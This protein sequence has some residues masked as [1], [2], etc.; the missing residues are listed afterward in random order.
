MFRINLSCV[1]S[2][3]RV[4]NYNFLSVLSLIIARLINIW[5]KKG[6]VTINNNKNYD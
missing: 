2:I 5:N 1:I 3:Q 6:H 4:L